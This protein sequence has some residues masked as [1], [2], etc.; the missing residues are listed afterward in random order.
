MRKILLVEDNPSIIMGLEYFLK[1][2]QFEVLT[3]TSKALAERELKKTAVDLVLL[4]ISLPDGSGC[5]LCVY[6]KEKDLAPVIFLTAKDEEKDVVKGFDLGADDYV[7]KPFRNR[8]L[9][10]RIKN[11]LRRNGKEEQLVWGEFKLDVESGKVYRNTEEIKVTKLEFQILQMMFS[12][13][14]KLFTREEILA[15]VWDYAGNFVNDNTLTVTIKRLREKMGDTDNSMIETVRGMGY[16]L[17]RKEDCRDK[18]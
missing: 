1:E 15:N 2:E 13:P 8:E 5:D 12:Y 18:K 17:R 10:A 3:A 16:R 4:D 7:I 11:V 6:I 9:L 14:K